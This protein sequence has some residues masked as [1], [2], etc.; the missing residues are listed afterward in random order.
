MSTEEGLEKDN[1]TAGGA[2]VGR[3]LQQAREAQEMSIADAASHLRLTRDVVEALE[4]G[5]CEVLPAP[6]FVRGYLRSY[7]RLLSIDEERIV[8]AYNATCGE[9]PELSFHKAG[10]EQLLRWKR[11]ATFA[12]VGIVVVLLA[13]VGSNMLEGEENDEVTAK[14]EEEPVSQLSETFQPVAMII[15]QAEA[16]EVEPVE[17]IV[18]EK[19]L[20]V[21][22]PEVAEPEPVAPAV[23]EPVVVAALIESPPV[24]TE[25][26]AEVIAPAPTGAVLK[27][28]FSGDSWVVVHDASGKRRMYDMGTSKRA[29]EINGPA[30]FRVFL[31]KADVVAVEI[32][33]ESFD[34]RPFIEGD[35]AR[36]EV[37]S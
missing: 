29:R 30:P 28:S 31:G 14:V 24:V 9:A 21:E 36:F 25:K 33:G 35:L 23:S 3:Q 6:A 4:A 18:A 32:D 22:A 7:A 34:H 37:G 20:V 11:Y 19:A 27:L 2:D 12:V 10:A 26:V 8:T 5:S 16:A 17:P 1:A 15:E 13:I